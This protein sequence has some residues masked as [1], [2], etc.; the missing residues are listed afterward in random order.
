MVPCFSPLKKKKK[1]SWQSHPSLVVNKFWLVFPPCWQIWWDSLSNACDE[2]SKLLWCEPC[3]CHRSVIFTRIHQSW[4]RRRFICLFLCNVFVFLW[5]RGRSGFLFCWFQRLL[6]FCF[7]WNKRRWCLELQCFAVPLPCRKPSF[8][9]CPLFSVCFN[10]M[11][12]MKLWMKCEFSGK[13]NKMS[14]VVR[15][16]SLTRSTSSANVFMSWRLLTTLSVKSVPYVQLSAIPASALSFLFTS[17]IFGTTL[18]MFSWTYHSPT[19]G[20]L[21]VAKKK[22][23]VT[24]PTVWYHFMSVIH[25]SKKRCEE[26]SEIETNTFVCSYMCLHQALSSASQPC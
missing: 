18:R 24:C 17:T 7:R 5:L 15:V 23:L 10:M 11:K 9:V 6:W 26:E 13:A 12:A 1:R 4:T 3:A 8:C 2:S 14:S 16:A 19:V 21:H 25:C 20:S 22:S